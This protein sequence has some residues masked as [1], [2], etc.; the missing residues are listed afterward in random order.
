LVVVVFFLIR[1]EI[2]KKQRQIYVLKPI[3]TLTVIAVAALS[4]LEPTRNATY[5]AGILVGLVFSFGGDLALMFQE[6]RKAFM[7]G[8]VLFLLAHVVYAVVFGL[9]GSL[10][11]WDILSTTVLLAVGVGF[12]T[13]IRTDLGTMRMPVIIY[14]LV[15]SVMVNRA[16]SMLVNPTIADGQAIMVLVGAV[17]FYISDVI[18]AAARFWKPW[19]YHRISLAF[20]YS[21]QLLIAL[22]ASYASGG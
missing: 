5:T 15:I 20:Y 16:A 4:L 18:L 13:L 12:Y 1:A 7:V 14:I 2:L 9:L 3:A 19:R 8:L 17:L 6:N 21:G 10:S 22:A 11:G